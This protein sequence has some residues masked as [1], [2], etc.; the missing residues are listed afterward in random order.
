MPSRRPNRNHNG[1]GRPHGESGEENGVEDK[2][3]GHH[4]VQND[5]NGSTMNRK[6]NKPPQKKFQ[7]APEQHNEFVEKTKDDIES[8]KAQVRLLFN[9][10]SIAEQNQKYATSL[11]LFGLNELEG[12][13]SDQ[14][15]VDR[16][17]EVLPDMQSIS[18]LA[19]RLGRSSIEGKA[20]PV[21]LWLP[22]HNTE[23]VWSLLRTQGGMTEEGLR[24]DKYR[25]R[26]RA[27]TTRR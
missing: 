5:R 4:E 14:Q 9:K 25:P 15:L 8:L 17:R 19:E 13:E 11:V 27:R 10:L 24:L 21:V 22:P 6:P 12:L 16:I 1:N 23:K 26:P 18:F 20:R 3:N 7:R 2:Y